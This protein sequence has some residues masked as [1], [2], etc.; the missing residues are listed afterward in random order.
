MNIVF[1]LNYH[2]NPGQSLWLKYSTVLDENGVRFDQVVP[3]QWINPEQWEVRVEIHGAGKIRIDYHYQLR[4]SGNGLRLD[5]WHGP[6]SA[7]LDLDANDA[8]LLLD[9]WCSAGTPDHAFETNA[10]AAVLPARGPFAELAIP[11]NANHSFQLRMAAVPVGLTP[12]II[13]S[14]SEIGDWGWHS[15]VPLEETAANV[16]RK[17][18]YLPADWNIEYKYGLFDKRLKCLVSMELG[19]NRFLPARRIG[20]RQWTR[21]SDEYYR[22]DV[23]GLFRGAGVA[24]PVFSLRGAQEPRRWRVRR[25]QALCGLGERRRSQADPDPADQRHHLVPPVDGLLPVFGDQR[26]RAAPDLPADRR[27]GL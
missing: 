4:Q 17:N 13:G 14:V 24:I 12:C 20:A 26:F 10:F 23:S 16:W 19:E 21:V 5:E 18:L 3:L 1:R 2:T 6:R 7:D 11:E 22:R 27:H 9:T 25:S 15:A 8:L